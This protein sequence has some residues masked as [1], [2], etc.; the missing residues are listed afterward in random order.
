MFSYIPDDR[1]MQAAVKLSGMAAAVRSEA[2]GRTVTLHTLRPQSIK[3]WWEPAHERMF[4]RNPRMRGFPSRIMIRLAQPIM[5]GCVASLLSGGSAP[6][7]QS[8]PVVAPSR[9][10]PL[11]TS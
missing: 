6:R 9:G 5:I 3:F 8:L 10:D 4:G 7:R 1:H 11:G 2:L